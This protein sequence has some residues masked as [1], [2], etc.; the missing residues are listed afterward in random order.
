MKR[1]FPLVFLYLL[2]ACVT[3]SQEQ[4]VKNLS[5]IILPELDQLVKQSVIKVIS[6]TTAENGEWAWD[7]KRGYKNNEYEVHYGFRV[8][9]SF[10]EKFLNG[11][12][13]DLSEKA[14]FGLVKYVPSDPD[15]IFGV[16]FIANLK[17]RTIRPLN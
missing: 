12:K 13:E 1:Y 15:Q 4:E 8:N 5:Y 9:H 17:T 3:N 11:I 16:H 10:G 7:I 2:S 14:T 6:D